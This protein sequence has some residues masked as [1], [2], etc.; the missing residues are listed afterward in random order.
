MKRIILGVVFSLL[1]CSAAFA[2]VHFQVVLWD[3]SN[4]GVV[5]SRTTTIY[6][7]LNL[8]NDGSAPVTFSNLTRQHLDI[9]GNA[10]YNLNWNY[11][12]N[13]FYNNQLLGSSVGSI[14][15]QPYSS[16]SIV[17]GNFPFSYA[18]SGA[19]NGASPKALQIGQYLV[20]FQG[21]LNG[22]NS[23]YNR[24]STLIVSN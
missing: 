11:G 18:V 3:A 9:E 1:F 10:N 21:N 8:T 5:T 24:Y 16:T 19:I 12:N 22:N 4:M 6:G 15:I 23:T 17:L 14:T 20:R 13:V 2:D 7:V